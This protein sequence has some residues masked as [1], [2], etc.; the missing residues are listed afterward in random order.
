MRSQISIL[1]VLAY[2]LMMPATLPADD[3]YRLTIGTAGNDSL[4][5]TAGDDRI[6]GSDGNDSLFGAEGND[7]HGHIQ[8]PQQ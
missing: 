7:I 4:A 6:E 2:L 8:H 5:G 1:A 3:G